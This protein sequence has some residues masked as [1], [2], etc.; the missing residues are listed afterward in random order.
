MSL[1]TIVLAPGEY[2]NAG[3]GCIALHKLA[4]NLALCGAE[5]YIMADSKNPD[6]KGALIDE[7]TAK[8][9]AALPDCMVI[10][11]EVVCGNPLN[12]KHI[13]RWILYHV[14]NYGQFGV[15]GENDLIY[16]YA[17]HFNTRLGNN[18]DGELRAMELDLS[19]WVDKGM[20]RYESCH[21]YKKAGANKADIH[22]AG[23]ICIDN[24]P[25][26]G[27]LESLIY[28][29]NQRTHFYSYDDATFLSAL[30]AL[31][32]CKSIVVP[33]DGVTES[34]WRGGFPYFYY[35]IAYGVE[36]LQW[37]EDTAQY[38]RAHLQKLDG[39]TITQTKEFI[40]N[41]KLR[42]GL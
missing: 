21:L 11:P 22:P 33:T 6:Y 17:A 25:Q 41:C 19:K 5:S 34:E 24:Y 28:M 8:G 39:A 42:M 1:K 26:N 27:G 32:G 15:F 16:K 14:R 30:A 37:A 29:F 38:L 7:T 20:P 18:I 23:S 4:H 35:G 31:C 36:N 9:I 10:Y 12:A 13:T 3:G 2:T 40:Y